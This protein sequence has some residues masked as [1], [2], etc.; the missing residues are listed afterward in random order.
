MHEPTA[1][2]DAALSA[3]LRRLPPPPPAASGWPRLQASLRAERRRRQQRRLWLTAAVLALA[4]LLPLQ[5]WRSGPASP[6]LPAELTASSELA[7]L[8][9]ESA[10][11]DDWL[12]QRDSSVQS[13]GLAALD[14]QII[15]RVQ[16]IDSLLAE[17]DTSNAASRALW[18]ERVLLLR[19]L[20][21]LEQPAAWLAASEPAAPAALISL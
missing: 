20:A 10:R 4:S 1:E 16:W 13:A 5:L 8:Q 2:F 6:T 18:G 9:A 11:L 7:A 17:A 14:E 3:A 12:R 15:E 19:Q 21:T